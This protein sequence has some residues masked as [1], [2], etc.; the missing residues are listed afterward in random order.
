MNGSAVNVMVMEVTH[1]LGKKLVHHVGEVV[2]N[3]PVLWMER[4]AMR[5]VF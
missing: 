1:L 4:L 2:K 5:L 3:K